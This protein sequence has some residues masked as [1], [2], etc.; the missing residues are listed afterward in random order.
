MKWNYRFRFGK[1]RSSIGEIFSFR[2]FEGRGLR[3]LQRVV[4]RDN[5]SSDMTPYDVGGI[6]G[7]GLVEGP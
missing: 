1:I 3:V 4:D 2:D 7:I 5:G 6:A